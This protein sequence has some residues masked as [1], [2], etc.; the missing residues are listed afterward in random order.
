MTPNFLEPPS[1]PSFQTVFAKGGHFALS[2]GA[3]SD[4]TSP[5]LYDVVGLDWTMDPQGAR[6]QLPETATLQVSGHRG[7]ESMN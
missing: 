3:L 1:F 2:S 6:Q 4:L 5:D 7:G